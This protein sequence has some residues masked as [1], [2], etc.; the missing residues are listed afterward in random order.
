[1]SQEK[2]MTPGKDGLRRRPEWK[3]L[4][5]GILYTPLDNAKTFEDDYKD[6]MIKV[7]LHGEGEEVN[8]NA[9]IESGA[10]NDFINRTVCEKNQIE[11]ALGK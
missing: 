10:T 3:P 8:I 1:M 2:T 4:I 6:I 11:T 5:V 7:S 9:R